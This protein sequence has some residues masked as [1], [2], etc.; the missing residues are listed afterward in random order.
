[1]ND[2]LNKE[3]TVPAYL[4]I[5]KV[6]SWL[7]Y[8]WVIYGVIVLSIRVFLLAFSANP[9]TPFVQFIYNTSA[10]YL[11]PFRGIFPTK[12]VGETG[13]L[14]VASLFAIIMYLLF[15]WLVSAAIHYIQ[16]K[17]DIL[18]EEEKERKE[19]LEEI[20]LT[21]SLQPKKSTKQNQ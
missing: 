3:I 1:M 8:I 20:E 5:S 21:K 15:V 12:P 2:E 7:L 16:S 4:K 19:K 14:D 10:D 6:I 17:I 18:K 13:Y 11:A 9:A